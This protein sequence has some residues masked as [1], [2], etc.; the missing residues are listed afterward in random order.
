MQC[1]VD[2]DD[3]NMPEGNHENIFS[4][5]FFDSRA[6]RKRKKYEN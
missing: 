6:K 4:A 1:D 3:G 5:S 2:D